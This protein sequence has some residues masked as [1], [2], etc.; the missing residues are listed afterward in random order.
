MVSN[1]NR[2]TAN[3]TK[4]VDILSRDF[5]K[6]FPACFDIIMRE[7]A[8]DK[9]CILYKVLVNECHNALRQC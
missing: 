6:I 1:L 7:E 2:S 4:V 5:I 9:Y 3:W 8:L